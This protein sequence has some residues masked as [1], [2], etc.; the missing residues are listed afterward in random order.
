[1]REITVSREVAAPAA[2]VWQILTDVE[3][4]PQVVSAIS[5]V[6]RVDGGGEFGVGTAWRETR[7][8][9][10]RQAT[11][12]LRVTAV[13]PGR[14][15]VVEADGRGARYRSTVAVE[16]V[17]ADHSRLSMTF[18]GEARGAMSR[19]FD[20]TFGRLFAGATRRALE[21]DLRDIAFAAEQ[22]S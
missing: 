6:E 1:M 13:D 21:Q 22:S 9:F 10:G 3:S 15:Y 16:P 7:E 8:A 2:H 4:A 11:E 18:G 12:E 17:N 5:D 19:A 14:A 20:A